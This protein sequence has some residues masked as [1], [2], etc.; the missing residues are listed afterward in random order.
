MPFK[1]GRE[2]ILLPEQS[3][4][5]GRS[6]FAISVPSS[7]PQRQRNSPQSLNSKLAGK[8]PVPRLCRGFQTRLFVA[9]LR[10]LVSSH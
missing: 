6:P 7:F 2:F 3:R 4:P 5:E 9:D 1:I 8:F 10:P